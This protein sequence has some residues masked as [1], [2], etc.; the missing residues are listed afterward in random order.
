M[1]LRLPFLPILVIT[2]L[3]APTVFA[4]EAG[5]VLASWYG[6]AH[7]GKKTAS[8]EPFD[9]AALTAAHPDLPFGTLVTVRRWSDGSEVVV[10]INDRGPSGHRAGIDLSAAAARRL[11]LVADGTGLVTL[12]PMTE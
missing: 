3:F 2:V 10:R 5:P 4:T 8:G 12:H 7:A 9:P 6:N 1:H 11:G